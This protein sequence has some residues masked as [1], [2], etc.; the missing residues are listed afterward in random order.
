MKRISQ[1]IGVGLPVVGAIFIVVI[2]TVALI[3]ATVPAA[4]SLHAATA[5]QLAH[6]QMELGAPGTDTPVVSS[7][8]A[9]A[10]AGAAFPAIYQAAGGAHQVV[11]ARVKDPNKIPPFDRLC[12]VVDLTPP[13]SFVMPGGPA[14]QLPIRKTAEHWFVVV[15]DAR[16]GQV[17][18]AR[19]AF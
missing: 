16:S 12:W 14:G 2:A 7:K 15:V 9:I 17:V 13:A 4:P 11:L 1:I 10:A 3:S 6:G 5:S 18:F 19:G 8:E